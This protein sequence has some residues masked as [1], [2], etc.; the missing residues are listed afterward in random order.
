MWIFERRS[1]NK[2][3]AGSLDILKGCLLLVHLWLLSCHWRSIIDWLP[4]M[5]IRAQWD[6][7]GSLKNTLVQVNHGQPKANFKSITPCL[8][9]QIISTTRSKSIFKAIQR[10]RIRTRFIVG[11]QSNWELGCY[12]YKGRTISSWYIMLTRSIYSHEIE[13]S[14]WFVPYHESRK[15]NGWLLLKFAAI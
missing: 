8:S 3:R 12:N 13:R 1:L 14:N 5:K 7:N 15:W 9:S 11:H 6:K 10:S 2:T 4:G